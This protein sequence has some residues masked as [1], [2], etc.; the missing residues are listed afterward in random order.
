MATI[1]GDVQ[2]TQ[3]GTVTNPCSNIHLSVDFLAPVAVYKRRLLGTWYF[4]R[5][6]HIPSWDT[7][8]SEPAP[9]IEIDGGFPIAMFES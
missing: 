5:V 2:Y 3:N 1:F 7:K 4:L 6:W 9:K 8:F